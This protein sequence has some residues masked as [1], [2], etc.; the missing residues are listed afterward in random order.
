MRALANCLLLL[1]LSP[2]AAFTPGTSTF[3]TFGNAQ[4]KDFIKL[5]SPKPLPVEQGEA[6]LPESKKNME[7]CVCVN[8]GGGRALARSAA[9]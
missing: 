8:G 5:W 3:A 4:A 6:F 2:A 7:R 9:R 1:A